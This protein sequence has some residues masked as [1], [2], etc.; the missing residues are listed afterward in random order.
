MV[1]IRHKDSETNA[2]T[3]AVIVARLMFEPELALEAKI[4]ERLVHMAL[5]RTPRHRA[6]F[7]HPT[8]AEEPALEEEDETAEDDDDESPVVRR[9]VKLIESNGLSVL[10]IGFGRMRE[11]ASALADRH[12]GEF[13]ATTTYVS[14]HDASLPIVP[15]HRYVCENPEDEDTTSICDIR[16]LLVLGAEALGLR[17]LQSLLHRFPKLRYLC[18]AGDSRHRRP[19]HTGEDHGDPFLELVRTRRADDSGPFCVSKIEPALPRREELY[20]ELYDTYLRN[21]FGNSAARIEP[22]DGED[23]ILVRSKRDVGKFE[24]ECTKTHTFQ[25]LA[26]NAAECQRV[27]REFCRKQDRR[28]HL[29][30]VVVVRGARGSLH[31]SSADHALQEDDQMRS[32]EGITGLIVSIE[33]LSSSSSSSSSGGSGRS[34][35]QGFS[36]PLGRDNSIK[37]RLVD[38]DNGDNVGDRRHERELVLVHAA[39]W[40]IY[41]AT[42]ITVRSR[43]TMISRRVD[44]SG[45]WL[46]PT[47]R[48]HDIY[49]AL[50][51]AREKFVVFC[52]DPSELGNA[53]SRGSPSS[54]TLFGYLC[55]RQK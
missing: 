14:D 43:P 40:S 29:N 27:H 17:M 49:A 48:W 18:L 6:H 41:H 26:N 19:Y 45:M 52:D 37:L 4:Y 10:D 13:L 3:G 53:L 15:L 31:S 54:R 2:A 33:R 7:E 46:S 1:Q 50:L 51:R 23:R 34:Q 25:C 36:V 35:T 9:I 47:T 32:S 8:G 11:V 20:A 42:C 28:F 55:A 21:S 12:P 22:L 39:G 16:S 38:L 24:S 30:D 44:V 5:K